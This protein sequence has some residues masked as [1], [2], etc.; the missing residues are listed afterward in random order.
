MTAPVCPREQDVINSIVTGRWPNQCDEALHAHAADCEVCRELIEVA[1]V[2]CLE[3]DGLHDEMS[4]PSAG[5]VWWRAAIRARLEASQQVVRPLSWLLGVAVACVIGL[6]IAVI[7]LLWSPA[8]LA[9]GL[10]TSWTTSFGLGEISRWLPTFADLTP[11]TTTGGFVLLGAAAC[12][13][14]APLALYFALS[15]E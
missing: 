6:T 7:E 12:L 3:R 2:L 4:V 9:L 10:A 11:L 5:Q 8:H 15:D 14:L 1:S 13:V